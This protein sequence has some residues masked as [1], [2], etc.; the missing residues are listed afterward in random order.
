MFCGAKEAGGVYR[1]RHPH[2]SP[3]YKLVER[4]FPQFEAVCSLAFP[5]PPI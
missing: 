4:F 1:P 3:F 5:N 2:E